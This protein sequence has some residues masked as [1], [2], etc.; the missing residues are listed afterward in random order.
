ML[1]NSFQWSSEKKIGKIPLNNSYFMLALFARLW[2]RLWGDYCNFSFYLKYLLYL[3]YFKCFKI[4]CKNIS[5]MSQGVIARVRACADVLCTCMCRERKY[6]YILK[7]AW[8]DIHL[9]TNN[10]PIM[11]NFSIICFSSTA[12]FIKSTVLFWHLGFQN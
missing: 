11:H 6:R 1:L 12:L 4:S 5:I 3:E 7:S 2:R 8:V 10:K 9:A